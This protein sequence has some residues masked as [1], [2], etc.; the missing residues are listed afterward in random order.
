ML[1][2]AAMVAGFPFRLSEVAAQLLRKAL[3]A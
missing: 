3:A 1:A 2:V